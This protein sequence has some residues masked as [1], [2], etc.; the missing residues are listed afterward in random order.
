MPSDRDKRFVS[1]FKEAYV[2]LSRFGSATEAFPMP[3]IIARIVTL[4]FIGIADAMWKLYF[5]FSGFFADDKEWAEQQI[6]QI[7][8]Y[9][10]EAIVGL[11]ADK[12]SEAATSLLSE[13]S[14][15]IPIK[16]IVNVDDLAPDGS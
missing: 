10:R 11:E 15:G 3:S 4:M 1:Y 13:L 16:E 12:R 6:P 8:D 7:Q 9:I 2:A 5:Y 14:G